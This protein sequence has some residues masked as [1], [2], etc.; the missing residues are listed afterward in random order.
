[1]K[2]IFSS[3]LPATNNRAEPPCPALVA[4][5]L[6]LK[7]HGLKA[8]GHHHISQTVVSKSWIWMQR[9]DYQ[10][11]MIA[12]DNY[13]ESANMLVVRVGFGIFAS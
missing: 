6:L 4:E 13:V 10:K 5:P 9:F 7:M 1:M 2:K 11:V 8:K 12:L 3:P